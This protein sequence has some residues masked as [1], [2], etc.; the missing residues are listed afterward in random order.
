MSCDTSD[1]ICR[2]LQIGCY[3]F[4]QSR[5]HVFDITLTDNFQLQNQFVDTENVTRESRSKQKCQHNGYRSVEHISIDNVSINLVTLILENS[6][7][8]DVTL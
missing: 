5:H 1:S 8:F 3:C 2:D 7:Q 6:G 4:Y